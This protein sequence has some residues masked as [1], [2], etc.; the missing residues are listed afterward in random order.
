MLRQPSLFGAS[1]PDFDRAFS[2]LQRIDLDANAWIDYAPAWLAGSDT[3]FD[4]ILT[5]RAWQQRTRRLW[6][7]EM[8]EPRWTS[9]WTLAS[10]EALRPAIVDA[11]RLALSSRYGVLLDSVGYNL[12]RDGRDSVAWHGDQIRRDI[13]E[14]VVALLSLGEA[15]RFLLRRRGGGPSMR[16]LLGGGDLFVTGGT[17]QRTWEHSVP[18]AA[19]AA[20]RISLAFRHGLAPAAYDESPASAPQP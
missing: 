5:A 17:T 4:Q 19:R 18:K 8:L 3:L 10:G 16:F 9:A 1:Q 12:Y 6:D 13:A 15:R 14:P 11:M 2:T 20:P 7:K